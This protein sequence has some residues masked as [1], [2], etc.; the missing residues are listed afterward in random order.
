MKDGRRNTVTEKGYLYGVDET[1]R[2]HKSGLFMT[3]GK[4]K[5]LLL[6]LPAGI[7]SIS[8]LDPSLND[9]IVYGKVFT[10]RKGDGFRLLVE[11]EYG[12]Y[13]EFIFDGFDFIEQ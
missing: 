10:F 11:D 3:K 8:I 2:L 9:L 12:D 6:K 4:N 1:I 5:V 7:R 13:H